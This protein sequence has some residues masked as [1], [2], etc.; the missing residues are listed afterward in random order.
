MFRFKNVFN[1]IYL[2]E[3]FHYDHNVYAI[4]F[5]MKKHRLSDDRYCLVYPQRFR[6]KRNSPT[7]NTNFLKVMNTVL[8]ISKDIIQKDPLASFGFMGAAKLSE[9]DKSLN[10]ENINPDNTIG[11]TKR[12]KVYNMY[13]RRYFNPKDFEYIDSKTASILLLRNNKNKAVLTKEVA[14]QY[15]VNQLIP[16]LQTEAS[17]I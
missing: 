4:K 6:E 13:A 5:F 17:I 1:D 7:G 10:E 3:V 14:E 8:M 12:Y 2:V 16:N 15:I 11:N 9:K